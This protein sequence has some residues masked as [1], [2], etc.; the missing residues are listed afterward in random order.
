MR[1]AQAFDTTHAEQA[2]FYLA[3]SAV[4]SQSV[5]VANVAPITF[6][7][8]SAGAVDGADVAE[9]VLGVCRVLNPGKMILEASGD[10]T[11]DGETVRYEIWRCPFGP[12]DTGHTT[13]V[14]SLNPISTEMP[15]EKSNEAVNEQPVGSDDPFVADNPS[16]SESS[17]VTGDDGE[18]PA[19]DD[20]GQPITDTSGEA[21][22]ATVTIGPDSDNAEGQGTSELAIG[23][24]GIVIESAPIDGDWRNSETV[25]WTVSES[26]AEALR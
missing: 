13:D 12:S 15:T 14:P 10:W 18:N 25:C 5:S 26:D 11:L 17:P 4:M 20:N 19:S 3:A 7:Q 16:V 8:P 21:E 1:D 6:D 23:S 2:A 24:D 9:G 22:V